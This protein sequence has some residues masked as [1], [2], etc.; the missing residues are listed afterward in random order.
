M[1]RAAHGRFMRPPHAQCI[2]KCAPACNPQRLRDVERAV[3]AL[4]E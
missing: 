1:L 3:R 2:L 4:V